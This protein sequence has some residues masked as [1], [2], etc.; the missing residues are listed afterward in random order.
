MCNNDTEPEPGQI[1]EHGFCEYCH[2][3]A[4]ECVCSFITDH[5]NYEGD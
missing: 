1:N 3:E 4:H 5:P 2:H